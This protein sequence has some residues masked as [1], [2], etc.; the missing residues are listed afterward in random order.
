VDTVLIVDDDLLVRWSLSQALAARGLRV[1]EA[2]CGAEAVRVAHQQDVCVAVLDWSLPDGDG[3]TLL[4]RLARECPGCRT[5]LLT[6]YVSE[7][8]DARA[9]ALGVAQVLGKP[10]EI[11][12]LV[13]RVAAEALAS[14]RMRA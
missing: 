7:E 4:P 10:Y 3:L 12:D 8:L 6:A 2:D 11:Q 1:L 9:R 5:L 14:H 13:Q